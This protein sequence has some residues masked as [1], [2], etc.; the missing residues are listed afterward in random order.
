MVDILTSIAGDIESLATNLNT[1]VGAQADA[2]DSLSNQVEVVATRLA[3]AKQAVALE[4]FDEM[5][6]DRPAQ[7]DPMPASAA[8]EAIEDHKDDQDD[9]RSE[10]S[11]AAQGEESRRETQAFYGGTGT[12]TGFGTGTGTGVGSGSRRLS[13][14]ERLGQL[15]EVGVC[16]KKETTAVRRSSESVANFLANPMN[17]AGL[18]LGLGGLTAAS[19]SASTGGGSAMGSRTSSIS[20]S[21]SLPRRPQM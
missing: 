20:A 18:G 9:D 7:N 2:V 19:A 13:M 15:D 16:L 3:M 11:G 6:T 10:T 14:E 1:Y 21:L 5:R 17:T 12:G 8:A 4:R